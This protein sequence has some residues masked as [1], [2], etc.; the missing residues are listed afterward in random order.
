MN[1]PGKK[2]NGPTK[3]AR[4]VAYEVIATRTSGQL[5]I[6][7]DVPTLDGYASAYIAAESFGQIIVSAL[8][9]SLGSGYAIE[10]IQVFEEDGSPHVFGVRHEE[11]IY[12]PYIDIFGQAFR[13][14]SEDVFFRLALRDY[15][16]AINDFTDCAAYCY[17][18]IEAIQSSFAFRDNRKEGWAEMHAALGTD[19]D[20]IERQVKDYADPIRNGNWAAAKPT[21]GAVRTAMLVVTRDVLR[22]YLD[23]ARLQD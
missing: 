22:R 3:P 19:R 5:S 7:L 4:H 20:S 11:L 1:A 10:I 6:A 9:F 8:G 23:H 12:D 21:T 18:A 15:V 13:L 14:A 16:R 17:R 2:R